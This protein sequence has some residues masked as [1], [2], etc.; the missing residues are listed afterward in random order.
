MRWQTK[1]TRPFSASV[2]VQGFRKI[3]SACQQWE[4]HEASLQQVV[5]SG[6]I[7]TN[8][9]SDGTL[10]LFWASTCWISA[11]SCFIFGFTGK[12]LVITLN[13]KCGKYNKVYFLRVIQQLARSSAE[14]KIA[15]VT[16]RGVLLWRGGAELFS[17]EFSMIIT[18]SRSQPELVGD[19]GGDVFEGDGRARD[20]FEPHAI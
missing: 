9:R 16:C 8:K 3:W 15:T 4:Q 2:D 13:S 5:T 11:V 18:G 14:H 6:F 12:H 19:F 10:R 1:Q 7:L 20:P 17:T